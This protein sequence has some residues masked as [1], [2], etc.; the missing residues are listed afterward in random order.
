[1]M[2]KKLIEEIR[3]EI[4]TWTTLDKNCTTRW[5]RVEKIIMLAQKIAEVIENK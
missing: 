3:Q 1:M 4:I 5:I 2:N